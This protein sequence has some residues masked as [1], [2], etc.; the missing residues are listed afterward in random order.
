M[1]DLEVKAEKLPLTISTADSEALSTTVWAVHVY[2]PDCFSRVF[3][4]VRSPIAS[5]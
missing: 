3:K 4:M 5:F 1:R 2:F